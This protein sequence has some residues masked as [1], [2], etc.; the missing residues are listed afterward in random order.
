[1]KQVTVLGIGNILLQDEGFGV[2][3]VEELLRRYTFPPYVQV[4][5]G[6]TLGMELLRFLTGTDK[7]IIIDAVKGDGPPGTL[8]EFKNQAVKSYFKEKVSMHE[9]GIQDVLATLEILGQ[10]IME[11]TV[12]GVQPD[13]LDIGL[14]LSPLAAAVIDPVV[15][16]VVR[17]LESWQVEVM[18]N[19]ATI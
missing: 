9:L 7:L 17:Q 3:A 4:L 1:M 16:R 8:Y 12:F 14:E 13:L 2:R 11:I 5:D 18:K 19:D 10:P 6:G 15:A